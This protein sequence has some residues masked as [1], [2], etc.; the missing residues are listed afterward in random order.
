VAKLARSP[1][2]TKK[3]GGPRPPGGRPRP[4]KVAAVAELAAKLTRGP[5]LLTE[6]R[7]LTV[8]ELAEL[9]RALA[10]AAEYRV[11]KN[12]LAAIA[13][14]RA[15]LD[16][17]VPLLE[18]PTAVAFVTGDVA[19][20]ARAL[21]EFARRAPSLVIKG[22]VFDGRVLGPE[23]ARQLATLEPREVML[24]KV[25]GLAGAPLGRA[26]ATLGAGLYRLGAILAQY[27]DRKAAEAA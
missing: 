12:T 4:E 6:F 17:L 7:G 27:R 8:P 1:K 2:A 16:G 25:A 15:G 11:V 19:T 21:A 14:R 3:V 24:A 22:G 5:A 9:R 20:V 13:A 18:G 23:E 10:G 26:A